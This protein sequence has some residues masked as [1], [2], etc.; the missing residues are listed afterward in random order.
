MAPTGSRRSR[1]CHT[2]ARGTTERSDIYALGATVYYVL[3]A[4]VPVESP[5]RAAGT[6]LVSLRQI[7][8]AVPARTQDAIA[9]AMNLDAQQRFANV[10]LMEQALY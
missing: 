1:R 4:R 6:A 5:Y 7:N 3:T 8:G 2:H 10:A 9:M